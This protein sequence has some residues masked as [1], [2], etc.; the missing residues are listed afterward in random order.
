MPAI[1]SLTTTQEAHSI[2]F[3]GLYDAVVTR[4]ILDRERTRGHSK[5]TDAALLEKITSFLGDNVGNKLSMKGIAD[6]LTSAGA[7]TTNKTVDSY[8][9]ALNEAYLFYKADR[10][11]LHGKEILR[12]GPK[13]YI[14]DLGLR[15]S[16]GGYR[17]TDMDRLLENTVYL[18]LLYGG[19]RVH[20]GKLYEKEVDFLA[21]KDGRT[22]YLQVTD[23]M[24]SEATREWE[25]KSL[26]SIRDSYEKLIVV[27]QGRYESDIGGIKMRLREL[28]WVG[29][30]VT[31]PAAWASGPSALASRGSWGRRCRGAPSP[32]RS[33]ERPWERRSVHRLAKMTSRSR[34][35]PFVYTVATRGSSS[36]DASCVGW[37]ECLNRHGVPAASP[38]WPPLAW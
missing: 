25:L 20:V 5:V 14:V 22:V 37:H 11:D 13:E 15:S 23:E 16:L 4:N 31:A 28:V 12:T 24:L 27:R 35:V 19:W 32:T 26:C 3:S 1:A 18:Q 10:Y 30:C 6:V 17:P 7:K 8:V 34:F 38:R 9:K 21:V 2:Y 33:R 29:G 36:C